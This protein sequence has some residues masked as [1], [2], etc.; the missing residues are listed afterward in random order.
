MARLL[1]F[2]VGNKRPKRPASIIIVSGKDKKE[3]RT[4]VGRKLSKRYGFV[5][6]SARELL[7]DQIAKNTEVGRLAL[8]NVRNHTPIE[9]TIMNGLIQSRLTQVD[10]QMQGFV[11]EGYPKSKGQ[12]VALKDI[13]LKPT[14]IVMLGGSDPSSDVNKELNDKYQSVILG[15]GAHLGDEQVFEKVCFQL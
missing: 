14:L 8:N 4:S 11:L 7:N 2:K 10:C 13:Y 15:T 3:Q 9:D 6:V 1:K 12:V 5:Y